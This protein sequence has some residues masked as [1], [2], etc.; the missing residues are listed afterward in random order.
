[1]PRSAC[2]D[3]IIIEDIRAFGHHGMLEAE[4]EIGQCFIVDLTCALDLERAAASDAMGDTVN[5]CDIIS[6]VTHV[7]EARRFNLIERL[8][9]SIIDAL[10]ALDS[11]IAGIRVRVRK[12][13]A[14]TGFSSG[15]VSVEMQRMRA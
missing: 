9:R 11:R 13:G 5:Y 12:P 14:P 8:A 7:V 2:M 15:N 3:H 1:M 4:K 10:F 6:A